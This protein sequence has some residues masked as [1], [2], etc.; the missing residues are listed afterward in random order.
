MKGIDA[1]IETRQ[2]A[3][4]ISPA[5]VWERPEPEK[6]PAL[7]PLS[8]ERIVRAAIAIA[9]TEGLEGMSLRNVG[10]SLDAGPMRLYGYVSTKEELLALMVDA[11]YG[12]MLSTE[13]ARG[14][15][16]TVLRA[17][18]RRTREA[19]K[20]HPWFIELLGGRPHLGPNALAHL[21][22]ALAALSRAPGFEKI[23]DVLEAVG[24]V[25]AYVIGRI[26]S[27]A[28]ELRAGRESGMNKGEWQTAS[29]PYIARMIETGRFPTIARA[30]RQAKH[31]AF[32]VSFDNGLECVLDG[33]ATRMA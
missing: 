26:H 18:A 11:V 27:Q 8:R 1:M 4:E 17:L 25:N 24:T 12:E 3:L 23:D 22:A 33:I 29:W 28:R 31:P 2:K 19:A 9:D 30:V 20:K 32:D 5:L 10:A 14:G 16:R 13:R 6:R 7:S 15:W 21:E